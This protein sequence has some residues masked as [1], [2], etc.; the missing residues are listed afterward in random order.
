M[1]THLLD[2][3]GFGIPYHIKHAARDQWDLPFSLV[4][5]WF[6]KYYILVWDGK[7]LEQ[8]IEN[9]NKAIKCFIKHDNI[10]YYCIFI[11]PIFGLKPAKKVSVSL[12]RIYG[13]S[14]GYALI[15]I[16]GY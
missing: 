1:V 2:K 15:K 10:V 12:R 14:T 3:E 4:D 9:D 8:K 13:E 6:D 5:Y 11:S 7:Y 16:K